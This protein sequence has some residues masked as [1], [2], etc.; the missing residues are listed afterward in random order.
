MFNI[1]PV[2]NFASISTWKEAVS[3]CVYMV[4]KT[5]I[6]ITVLILGLTLIKYIGNTIVNCKKANKRNEFISNHNSNN[7]SKCENY[8]SA[9]KDEE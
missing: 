7:F 2:Y 4:C 5:A 8:K 1:L 9:K 6:V 3:V